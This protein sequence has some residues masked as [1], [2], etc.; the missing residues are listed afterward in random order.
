MKSLS[1]PGEHQYKKNVFFRNKFILWKKSTIRLNISPKTGHLFVVADLKFASTAYIWIMFL[2]L[3]LKLNLRSL[4]TPNAASGGKKTFQIF[5]YCNLLDSPCLNDRVLLL[6]SL[7]MYTVWILLA[8]LPGFKYFIWLYC[9]TN[10]LPGSTSLAAAAVL[11][12]VCIMCLTS[13][14]IFLLL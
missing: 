12:S 4:N 11:L 9:I 1:F 13:S 6:K 7:L 2:Y 5:I 8:F 10:G 14:Y 3:V